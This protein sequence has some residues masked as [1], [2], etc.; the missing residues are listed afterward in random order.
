MPENIPIFPLHTVLFPGGLLSL[1]IFEVRYID[2]V[3]KCLQKESGFGVCLIKQGNE[4]GEAAITETI[5]TYARI[6]D[7]QQYPDGILGITVEGQQRFQLLNTQVQPD[8]LLLGEIIRIEEEQSCPV[9]DMIVPVPARFQVL[10]DLFRQLVEQDKISELVGKAVLDDAVR[11]GYSLSGLL[12]VEL[13][14]RQQLLELQ[15]PLV[16][17]DWL[18]EWFSRV[19]VSLRPD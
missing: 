6:K 19:D 17:L 11:L 14:E 18:S 10:K 5:G 16:R 7:F 9:P 1:K 15:D 13:Q 4:V 12:P 2:M 8:N 3:S